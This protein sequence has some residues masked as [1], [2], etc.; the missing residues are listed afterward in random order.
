VAHTTDTRE[1][2][3]SPKIGCPTQTCL[4]GILTGS[5]HSGP[6]WREDRIH[7]DRTFLAEGIETEAAPAPLL[8]TLHQSPDQRIA[9]HVAQLLDA[10]F[11]GPDVEVVEARL[12][13][14][15]RYGIRKEPSLHALAPPLPLHSSRNA[16]LQGFNHGREIFP[17]GLADQQVHVLRHHHVSDGDLVIACS[18]FECAE[19]HVATRGLGEELPAPVATKVMKCR[20]LAP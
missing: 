1:D 19:E 20:S 5:R 4:C 16:L 6:F 15:L 17:L 12:P 13:E 14:T 11:R 18:F 7:R 3:L 8:R 9:V 2:F 10:L